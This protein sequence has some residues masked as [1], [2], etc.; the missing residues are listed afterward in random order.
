MS[1]LTRSASNLNMKYAT[2]APRN[3]K[4]Q[5]TLTSEN[6]TPS[7]STF[8]GATPVTE[9]QIIRL[10]LILTGMC[11][12]SLLP[13]KSPSAGGPRRGAAGMR[14]QYSCW[15][16]LHAVF[17]E[18]LRR[19]A[20]LL[21]KS[22]S[23]FRARPFPTFAAMSTVDYRTK[24]LRGAE[25]ELDAATKRTEVDAAAKKLQR[26]KAELKHLEAKAVQRPKRSSRGSG[27]AGASS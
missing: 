10:S 6:P 23:S 7:V 22:P 2:I 20:Y 16:P 5:H 13:V 27:S 4:I 8:E 15:P 9:T 25:A 1:Y 14:T 17:K 19:A 24:V 21:L 11:V 3:M 18:R 12:L 26:A